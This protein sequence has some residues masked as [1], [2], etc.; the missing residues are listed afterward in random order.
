MHECLTRPG[1]NGPAVGMGS[2]HSG[3]GQN[4]LGRELKEVWRMVESHLGLG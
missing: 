1:R 4:E 3:I 2:H